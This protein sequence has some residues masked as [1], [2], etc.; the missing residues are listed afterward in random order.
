[1]EKAVKNKQSR[2]TRYRT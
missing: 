1:M 2:D